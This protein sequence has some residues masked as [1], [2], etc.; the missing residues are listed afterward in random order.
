MLN[1]IP[2]DGVLQLLMDHRNFDLLLLY[3]QVDFPIKYED[4][5]I[6]YIGTIDPQPTYRDDIHIFPIRYFSTWHDS[7]SGSLFAFELIDR[8]FSGPIFR[9]TRRPY[10]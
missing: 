4:F 6:D 5:S 7:F 10:T 3:F 9:V 1:L 8:G 2:Y